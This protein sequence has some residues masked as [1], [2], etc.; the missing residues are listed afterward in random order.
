[1]YTC[2]VHGIDT[3]MCYASCRLYKM[4]TGSQCSLDQ[5]SYLLSTRYSYE[6]AILADYR[7]VLG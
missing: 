4:F 7:K 2:Q 6:C 5:W 1:M 3:C